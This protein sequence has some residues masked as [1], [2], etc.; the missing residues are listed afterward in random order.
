MLSSKFS[1]MYFK[2]FM[3]V[4]REIFNCYRN[5]V[6]FGDDLFNILRDGL[7]TNEHR[8]LEAIVNDH[9]I[10][11]MGVKYAARGFVASKISSVLK[12]KHYR[13]MKSRVTARIKI[14]AQHY[15]I[16]DVVQK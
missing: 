16:K 2:T 15:G 10:Y 11:E 7:R 1:I 6:E 12:D 13:E 14:L 8:F 3:Y 5:C 9:Y 4:V